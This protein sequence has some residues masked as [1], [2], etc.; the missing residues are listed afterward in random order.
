MARH[1]AEATAAGILGEPPPLRPLPYFWS[2]QYAV[3]YQC[4]G[5][6]DA[7]DRVVVEPVTDTGGP[8]VAR[9]YRVGELCGVFAADAPEAI[10]A[11]RRELNR[12]VA[13][14]PREVQTVVRVDR[15]VCIG[16][17]RCVRLLPAVFELDDEGIAE[18]KD[19]GTT[20]SQSSSRQP[21]RVPAALSISTGTT[22]NDRERAP[23]MIVSLHGQ[24]LQAL[25]PPLRCRWA[26]QLAPATRSRLRDDELLR[27][28]RRRRDDAGGDRVA[29]SPRRPAGGDRPVRW[30]PAT[31]GTG[32]PSAGVRLGLQLAPHRPC[33]RG[34]DD[35]WPT[36]RCRLMG[37]FPDGREAVR[38]WHH[39]LSGHR[40]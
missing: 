18:V 21:S 36:R 3:R 22:A 27:H 32:P 28:P 39:L 23:A 29:D 11:A 17:G 8:F 10:V 38:R 40:A 1:H 12:E 19:A 7:T 15:D 14:E 9:Y 24:G 37:E 4:I 16:N 26:C 33:L 30:P 5:S 31:R 13:N 25:E 6:L 2:E 34:E 35:L 20:S